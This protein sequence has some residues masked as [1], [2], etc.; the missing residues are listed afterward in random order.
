MPVILHDTLPFKPWMAEK[1]RRLPGI[2]PSSPD[3]WLL[4]DEA[5]DAQ[6][7]YRDTLISQ[8][9]SDV[10]MQDDASN[11]AQA[12]TLSLVL[13]SLDAGYSRSGDQVLRPDG[14]VVTLKADTPALILA[15]Q[16]VQEDLLLLERRDGPHVL[17]A[18][19]L[20]FPASWLL[21]EK[22]GKN[23][24]GIHNVVGEYGADMAK[25]VQRMFD[26]MRPGQ[27]LWRANFLMYR[28]ADLFQPRSEGQSRTDS[29]P[30]EGFVRVERQT[31]YKLP[32]TGAV[33][34]GVHTYV[35]NSSSLSASERAAL[36]G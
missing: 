16:L 22:F 5:F 6:M 11:P 10:F 3:Q 7:A 19:V 15:A 30:D 21:R 9:R 24:V 18:G 27:V 35:V 8:R 20:C 13:R 34:F 31:L 36:Q 29:T 2:Q 4:R 14:Q 32:E 25:R 26:V 33:V 28:D 23:L 1:T 17:S 12:E